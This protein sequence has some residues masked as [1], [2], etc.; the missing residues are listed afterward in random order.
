[1]IGSVEL[2]QFHVSLRLLPCTLQYVRSHSCPFSAHSCLLFQFSHNCYHLLLDHHFWS[3]FLAHPFLHFYKSL[4]ASLSSLSFQPQSP[5]FHKSHCQHPQVYC[6]IAPHL[7]CSTH[8]LKWTQSWCLPLPLPLHQTKWQPYILMPLQIVIFPL[9]GK[10]ILLY[11]S[12]QFLLYFLNV[13]IVNL[14]QFACRPYSFFQHKKI[15]LF[16]YELL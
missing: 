9:R 3:Q 4:L 10:A 16:T 1:M 14:H 2:K 5:S 13:A 7:F 6:T 12:N 11:I 15:E 8:K